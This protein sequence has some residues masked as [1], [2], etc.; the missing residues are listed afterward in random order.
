MKDLESAECDRLRLEQPTLWVKRQVVP[1]AIF[2]GF[3]LVLRVAGV[4]SP[5]IYRVSRGGAVL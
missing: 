5:L 4:S 3:L 1:F 2:M